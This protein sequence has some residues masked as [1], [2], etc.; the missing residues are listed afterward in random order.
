MVFVGLKRGRPNTVAVGLTKPNRRSLDRSLPVP[1]RHSSQMDIFPAPDKEMLTNNEPSTLDT[2][3]IAKVY[4][5]TSTPLIEAPWP[6]CIGMGWYWYR[7]QKF[8]HMCQISSISIANQKWFAYASTDIPVSAVDQ[9]CHIL[10]K[11]LE[12]LKCHADS[13][14]PWKIFEFQ[15]E[16]CKILEKS[17]N[18][19]KRPLKSLISVQG[20]G[21][22]VP[23]YAHR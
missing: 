7:Y 4:K 15:L 17:L 11:V 3:P 10:E 8:R 23:H 14:N 9:G 16:F 5:S 20:T 2:S 1:I 6:P 12:I 19:K 21:P 22:M 18:F 13:W